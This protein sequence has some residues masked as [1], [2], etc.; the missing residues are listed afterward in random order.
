MAA[1]HAVRAVA[2]SHAVRAVAASYAVWAVAASCAVQEEA[3]VDAR[4]DGPCARSS[5]SRSSES[6]TRSVP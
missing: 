6:G 1:S 5:A 3:S 4:D 2:A